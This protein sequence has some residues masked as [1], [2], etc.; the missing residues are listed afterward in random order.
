MNDESAFSSLFALCSIISSS[1]TK[2]ASN[3]EMSLGKY[4]YL[5]MEFY[6][7]MYIRWFKLQKVSFEVQLTTSSVSKRNAWHTK[8]KMVSVIYGIVIK[9]H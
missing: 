4:S 2:K 8:E 5:F 7:Y 1:L 9:K 6:T 3:R